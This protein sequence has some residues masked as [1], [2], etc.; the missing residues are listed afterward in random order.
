MEPQKERFVAMGGVLAMS[1]RK[2]TAHSD[3]ND[4][5]SALGGPLGAHW[6]L[7]SDIQV[8]IGAIQRSRGTVQGLFQAFLRSFRA[9]TF[10]FY[11]PQ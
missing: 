10:S 6:G 2:N 1:P 11:V 5:P 4:P 3:K 7:M 9:L 8:T